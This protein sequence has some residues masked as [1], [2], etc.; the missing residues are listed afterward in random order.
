MNL[1]QI[2]V[3][4]AIMATGSVSNAARL[5][6]VSVP[7][8]SRVLAHAESQ[9]GFLLFERVKGRL[10]PTTEA[11]RLF[12]EVEQVYKGV[13]RIERLTHELAQRRHTLLRVVCSP[14]IGQ[15]VIPQALAYFASGN[16]D[17]RVYFQCMNYEFL[18]EQLLNR[19][20]DVGVS[21]LP[22][23]HPSLQTQPIARSRLMC[24]CPRGHALA[25]QTFVTPHDL[26]A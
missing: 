24:I 19:Q 17:V 21:I 13:Q 14:S 9:L 18:K 11:R 6:H 26:S 7:A 16:P 20:V 5:L 15:V 10:H 8:V 12:V 1:R 3:F 2:E 23:D 25:G 4:K 22:V